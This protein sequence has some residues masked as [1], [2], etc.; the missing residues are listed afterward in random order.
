MSRGAPRELSVLVRSVELRIWHCRRKL[1]QRWLRLLAAMPGLKPRPCGISTTTRR[2]HTEGIERIGPT[3]PEWD[4][5]ST[6]PT[7]LHGVYRSARAL[8]HV[9]LEAASASTYVYWGSA[10]RGTYRAGASFVL[11]S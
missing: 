5:T 3:C 4:P 10:S 1:L 8:P 11:T 2:A 6:N 9:Q 7:R